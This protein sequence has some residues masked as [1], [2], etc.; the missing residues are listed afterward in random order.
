MAKKRVSDIAK[1]SGLPPKEVVEKL[2]KAG[3]SVKAAGSA[4]DE[5]EAK[6]ILGVNGGGEGGEAAPKRTV[7]RVAIDPVV[8]GRPQGGNGGR[9]GGGRDPGRG[10]QGRG[11]GTQAGGRGCEG[12]GAGGPQGQGARGAQGRAPAGPGG[13]RPAGTQGGPP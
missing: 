1:E 12:R 6:K 7:R 8:P 2:Q 9:Q 10:V 3:L 13:N 11:G 4:V 5:T